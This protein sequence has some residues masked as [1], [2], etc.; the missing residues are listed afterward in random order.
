MQ[1]EGVVVTANSTVEAR[2]LRRRD[3]VVVG[4]LQQGQSGVAFARARIR[5]QYETGGDAAQET[6]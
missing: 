2:E 4:A 3:V 6:I 1:E 5:G